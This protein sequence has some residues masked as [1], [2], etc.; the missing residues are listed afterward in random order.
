MDNSIEIKS[1]LPVAALDEAQNHLN[2]SHG[3][4]LI[5]FSMISQLNKSLQVVISF[6]TEEQLNNSMT[7]MLS[8]LLITKENKVLFRSNKVNGTFVDEFFGVKL[9]HNCVAPTTSDEFINGSKIILDLEKFPKEHVWT[10]YRVY[11]NEPRVLRM[12]VK[13]A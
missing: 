2:T 3:H 6:D 4:A 9:T 7:Q 10:F 1:S 13:G 8:V 12:K 5:A 11:E